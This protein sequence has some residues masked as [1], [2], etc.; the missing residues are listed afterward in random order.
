MVSDK[1]PDNPGSDTH[2]S[3]KYTLIW[4]DN[5]R[6]NKCDW[7]VWLWHGLWLCLALTWCQRWH[8]IPGIPVEMTIS[9]RSRISYY[10]IQTMCTGWVSYTYLPCSEHVV[11][12]IEP[13]NH[14]EYIIPFAMHFDT[15]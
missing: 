14:P 15:F 7:Q 4:S 1:V 13:Q 12:V 11:C 5:S 8:Q 2:G 9:H 3:A 10:V 6:W